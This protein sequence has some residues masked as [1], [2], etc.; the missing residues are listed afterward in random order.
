M[1]DPEDCPQIA[2]QF[3]SVL[4]RLIDYDES[5]EH[6][7]KLTAFLEVKEKQ[8]NYILAHYFY[9]ATQNDKMIF[10]ILQNKKAFDCRKQLNAAYS[11]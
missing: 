1:T 2:A 5:S 4:I 3:Y 6:G 7:D 8:F 11:Y 9:D 10:T